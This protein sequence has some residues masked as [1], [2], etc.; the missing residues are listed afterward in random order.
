MS[1][2]DPRSFQEWQRRLAEAALS[3]PATWANVMQQPANVNILVDYLCQLTPKIKTNIS[4]LHKPRAHRG[5]PAWA[6]WHIGEASAVAFERTHDARLVDW[7]V[8][9]FDWLLARRDS[10]LQRPDARAGFP[11]ASWGA[12]HYDQEAVKVKNSLFIT[13][14]MLLP[15]TRMCEALGEAH[16]SDYPWAHYVAACE[17]AANAVLGQ[18]HEFEAGYWAYQDNGSLEPYNHVA[19]Y[20]TVLL[21]LY[22]LTG[23]AVYRD[24]AKKLLDF[25]YLHIERC[26]GRWTWGYRPSDTGHSRPEPVWKAN[27]TIFLPLE[28]ARSGI[29]PLQGDAKRWQLELEYTFTRNIWRGRRNFNSYLCPCKYQEL[30]PSALKRLDPEFWL[31][32]QGLAAWIQVGKPGGTVQA[33]IEQ[34][35]CW[36][37]D[38]FPGGWFGTP[39]TA[40]AYAHRL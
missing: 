40:Y 30:A 34:A 13:A 24:T 20:A 21:R 22:K 32:M 12:L 8:D 33:I 38:I 7:L 15:T 19:P 4:T 26:H 2:S 23:R 11:L 1:D 3:G 35:I 27:K 37:R 9:I 29:E 36:R 16:V 5:S 10:A 39:A 31:R 18:L 14:L 6:W 25:F 17:G 28:A